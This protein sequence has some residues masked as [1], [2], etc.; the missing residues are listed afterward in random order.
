VQLHDIIAKQQTEY[1]LLLIAS[2]YER[3]IRLR[4]VVSTPLLRSR[5]R[6]RDNSSVSEED[7]CREIEV[8]ECA[9]ATKTDQRCGIVEKLSRSNVGRVRW[10]LAW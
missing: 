6:L 10:W 4:T 7:E 2:E 3:S 9:P 8:P 5:Y 1:A